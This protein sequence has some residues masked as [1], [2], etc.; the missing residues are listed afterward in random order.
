MNDLVIPQELSDVDKAIYLVRFADKAVAF[1]RELLYKIHTEEGWKGKYDSWGEFVEDGLGKSQGWA[2]KN[3]QVYKHYV[4]EGGVGLDR[5]QFDTE[6]LYLASKTG[7]DVEL[8]LSRA[9]TLK[10]S[11]LKKERKIHAHE[12]VWVTYCDV[13][14]LSQ[15]NH[16]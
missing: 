9:E 15:E 3:L 1:T 10:R 4:L 2:S 8:Q 14:G 7:D 16:E 5:L 11:D 6:K 12:P 13:C